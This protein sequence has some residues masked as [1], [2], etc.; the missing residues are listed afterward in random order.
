[1]FGLFGDKESKEFAHRVAKELHTRV[2][3]ALAKSD[4]ER[5]VKHVVANAREYRRNHKVGVLGLIG[6]SRA[7]QD[8]LGALGYEGDFIKEITVALARTMREG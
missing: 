3:P 5:A 7:F 1:V 2:P 6:L 4:M 8:E